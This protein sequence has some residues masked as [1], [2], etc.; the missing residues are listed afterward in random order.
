MQDREPIWLPVGQAGVM[1]L[2]IPVYPIGNGKPYFGITCS[3]HGNEPAGVAIVSRFIDLLDTFQSSD[4]LHGT[5]YIIPVANPPAQFVNS[6]V[7]PLDQQDPNRVGY[8]RQDGTSTERIAARL[9]EFLSKC[10]IVVNIHEF[11]MHT[12]LAAAYMNAGSS[13]VRSRS[14]AAIKAF[15]PEIIWVIDSSQSSDVQYQTTLDTALAL[16]RVANFPIETTQLALLKDTEI[17]RAVQGLLKVADHLGIV[18]Y[19][20]NGHSVAIPAFVREEFRGDQ[21]G[22]WEPA[23][24]PDSMLM[25]SIEIGDT[26][27]TLITLPEFIKHSI[28]SKVSGILIQQRHRELVGTGTSLFSIGYKADDIVAPY[29]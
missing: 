19:P 9:F 26:I 16:A 5:V 3:V 17:N 27:G 2:D 11:E 18:K 25:Q 4:N 12:P 7:S 29:I 21:A 13:E 28:Q 22:L 6:R 10:D 20:H 14:L 1:R 23:R 15:S 24:E 8:G